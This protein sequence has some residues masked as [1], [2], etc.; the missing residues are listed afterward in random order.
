[1]RFDTPS[2]FVTDCRS[3]KESKLTSFIADGLSADMSS[4]ITLVAR[5]T[6]SPIATAL[7]AALGA[8]RDDALTIRVVLFDIDSVVEDH[9]GASILDL[10]GAE[11]RILPDSR[12]A[13]AHEQLVLSANRVWLGDCMRRDPAKRDAFEV[14]HTDHATAALHA[15]QSFTKLWAAGEPLKRSVGARIAP[16]ALV[17]GQQTTEANTEFSPPRG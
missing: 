13:A 5:G 4:V 8:V 14:F 17:A 10:A 16:H 7:V 6:D 2:R 12:F 9:G 1:M 15:A 3:E 11:F